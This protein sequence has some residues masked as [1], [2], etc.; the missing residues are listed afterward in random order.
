MPQHKLAPP[1]L[2]DGSGRIAREISKI[3]CGNLEHCF[4]NIL[5][6]FGIPRI[7]SLSPPTCA[8]SYSL[9]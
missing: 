5:E 7:S 4:G 6:Y 3:P 9:R 8:E 2:N 1:P